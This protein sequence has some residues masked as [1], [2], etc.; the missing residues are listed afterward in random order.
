MPMMKLLCCSKSHVVRQNFLVRLVGVSR[1]LQDVQQQY[2]AE[3][4]RVQRSQTLVDHTK[5]RV[6]RFRDVDG[7]AIVPNFHLTKQ[8][9]QDWT[10]LS[11]FF[12]R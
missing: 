8:D 12:R 3:I 5:A 9:N 11:A 10:I 1:L 6:K 7:T 4:T 2:V